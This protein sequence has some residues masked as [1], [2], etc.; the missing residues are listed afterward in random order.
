MAFNEWLRLFYGPAELVRY[1]PPY[2]KAIYHQYVEV[3]NST[4]LDERLVGDG[5]A[6]LIAETK[7]ILQYNDVVKFLPGLKVIDLRRRDTLAH[8]VSIYTAQTTKR[9][10]IWSES[11]LKDY[12]ASTVPLNERQLLKCYQEIM[13]LS[14]CWDR[15][16]VPPEQSLTVFYEDLMN[17]PMGVGRDVLAFLGISAQSLMIQSKRIWKMTRPDAERMKQTLASLT[18][19]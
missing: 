1:S 4:A 8:A 12:M 11:Q 5:Y 16:A 9:F 7:P 14:N 10:H 6:S 3:C 2:L 18:S 17:D 15:F 13:A 19:P